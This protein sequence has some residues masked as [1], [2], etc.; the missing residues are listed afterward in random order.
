MSTAEFF[1]FAAALHRLHWEEH[2]CEFLDLIGRVNDCIFEGKHWIQSNVRSAACVSSDHT[3]VENN[4]SRLTC[5]SCLEPKI[6]QEGMVSLIMLTQ[7]FF[8]HCLKKTALKLLTL[9]TC[10]G[11]NCSVDRRHTTHWFYWTS[12]YLTE[13]FK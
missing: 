4:T 3:L 10:K 11:P 13:R 6:L 2:T 12:S 7:C 8:S 5:L 9:L 1:R